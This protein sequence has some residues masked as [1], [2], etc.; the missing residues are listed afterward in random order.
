MHYS[1]Y[2]QFESVPQAAVFCTTRRI[3]KHYVLHVEIT[4]PHGAMEDKT[5]T[6]EVVFYNLDAII[7]VGCRVS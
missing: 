1:Y 6:K 2:N 4:T 5:Q 7:A 3:I